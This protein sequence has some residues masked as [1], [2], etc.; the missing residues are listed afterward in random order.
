MKKDEQTNEERL[1]WESSL[2][3]K[4]N[5]KSDALRIQRKSMDTDASQSELRLKS[6]ETL[7][8]H[9]IVQCPWNY[10]QKDIGVALTGKAFKYLE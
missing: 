4:D 7:K 2:P 1:V 5:F 10:K 6:E 8:E 9:P 3:N